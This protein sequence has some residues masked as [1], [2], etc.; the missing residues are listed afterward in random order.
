MWFLLIPRRNAI[1][2][3]SVF[4]SKYNPSPSSSSSSRFS[5]QLSTLSLSLLSDLTDN[6][7]GFDC[8]WVNEDPVSLLQLATTN[9]LCVLF[10]LSKIGYV[11]GKLKVRFEF[12]SIWRT[13]IWSKLSLLFQ[14]L[15]A[16]K[17]VLK[18]G[19]APFDDGRKLT[20][21]FGCC[22]YGTLDLRELARKLNVT[23]ATG[24]ASLAKEYLGIEMDKKSSV[25]RGDWNA[26]TLTEEQVNYAACDAFAS[27]LIYQQVR[28]T[29]RVAIL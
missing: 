15:L 29:I 23:N 22:V 16:N 24:L 1:T 9:G 8:E 14:E 28:M 18:V 5:F 27:V 21:D 11:P 4:V 12:F 25:R 10:R 20:R 2:P 6:V 13:V 19:V 7:L 26:D 3:C 17:R